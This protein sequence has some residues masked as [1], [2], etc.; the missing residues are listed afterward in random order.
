MSLVTFVPNPKHVPTRI[1]ADPGDNIFLAIAAENKAHS[2]I[3]GDNHLLGLK[4]H[5]PIQNVTPSP[6][7]S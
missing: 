1:D 5:E 7:G 2:I 6:D 4:E 3:S